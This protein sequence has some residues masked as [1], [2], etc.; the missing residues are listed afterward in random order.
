M[1][2]I[3]TIIIQTFLIAMIVLFMTV[4]K[5]FLAQVH[6]FEKF[7][8]SSSLNFKGVKGRLDKYVDVWISIGTNDFVIGTINNG[9]IIPFLN[10]PVTMFMINNK[11]AIT[12]S[13]F[14]EQAITEL[15]ENGCAYEV[16]FKPFAVNPLSVPINK[17]EKKSGLF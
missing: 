10:P 3:R 8:V 11:S 13:E 2:M 17:S 14:V 6:F 9:Y 4:L 7:E 16:P 12:N 1:F 15:V 5:V